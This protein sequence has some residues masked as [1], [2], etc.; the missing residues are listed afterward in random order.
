MDDVGLLAY[1]SY[2]WEVM[3]EV[4]LKLSTMRNTDLHIQDDRRSWKE[5][6]E[7]DDHRLTKAVSHLFDQRRDGHLILPWTETR[8]LLRA[9]GWSLATG[10]TS[11]AEL[12]QATKAYYST[13]EGFV[14][15]DPLLSN[16]RRVAGH[17]TREHDMYVFFGGGVLA[18]GNM[19][20]CGDTL[21][22][23]HWEELFGKV[24]LLHATDDPDNYHVLTRHIVR[25]T[26]DGQQHLESFLRLYVIKCV[27]GVIK[28]LSSSAS[29]CALALV[30]LQQR[31][32]DRVEW[33]FGWMGPSIVNE[34]FEE[35]LSDH[36]DLCHAVKAQVSVLCQSFK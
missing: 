15:S 19:E 23:G 36:P 9:F 20:V 32:V 28:M 4:G 6:I 14:T 33:I 1:Y 25:H 12:I 35:V 17:I 29:G 22:N 5:L 8:H 10:S 26:S 2:E 30:D 18:W 21:M 27:Q 24:E 11:I 16:L 34:A 31:L 3:D 13:V 7:G